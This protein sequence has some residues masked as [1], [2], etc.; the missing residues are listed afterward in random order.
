MKVFFIRCLWVVLHIAEIE[1]AGLFAVGWVA[2]LGF[3]L[4]LTIARYGVRSHFGINGNPVEDFF[5]TL[6]LYPSVAIQLDHAFD[7][8]GLT[9][10]V[11]RSSEVDVVFENENAN[12]TV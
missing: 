6:V 12:G 2:Y 5:A 7:K 1:V 4:L 8:L 10:L 3:I 9:T 11:P